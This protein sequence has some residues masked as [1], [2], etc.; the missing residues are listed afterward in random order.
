[1]T[2][3]NIKT[4][5]INKL[6][7]SKRFWKPQCHRISL[8][9]E[10]KRSFY[11][12]K[13]FVKSSLCFKIINL[14]VYVQKLQRGVVLTSNWSNGNL[15]DWAKDLSQYFKW[16]WSYKNTLFRRGYTLSLHLNAQGISAIH[17]YKGFCIYVNKRYVHKYTKPI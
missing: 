4:D 8:T 11:T 6:I 12:V 2:S 10:P 5:V 7:F 15:V 17:G 13:K 16:F 9:W 14:H 1:M 3:S